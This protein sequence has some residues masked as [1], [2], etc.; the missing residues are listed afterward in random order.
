MRSF[1]L[2]VDHAVSPVALCG[3]INLPVTASTTVWEMGNVQER[4][5]SGNS[6]WPTMVFA[7]AAPAN[8]SW[9]AGLI[10]ASAMNL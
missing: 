8:V 5:V 4:S 6:A 9:T 7:T 2:A 3:P 1:R 10:G